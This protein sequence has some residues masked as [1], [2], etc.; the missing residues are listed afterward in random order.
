MEELIEKKSRSDK[1]VYG[2]AEYLLG[3]LLLI[4]ARIYLGD[5]KAPLIFTPVFLLAGTLYL[6]MKGMKMSRESKWLILC[7]TAIWGW[8]LLEYLPNSGY[9]NY[10]L[11]SYM[12]LFLHGAG[13]YWVL[14]L[15]ESRAEKEIG[16]KSAM[17][18]LRGIIILPC[19]NFFRLFGLAGSL[20]SRFRVKGE[21]ISKEEQEKRTYISI[22]ILASIPV[23]I[24]ILPLLQN[25]DESFA[26][27]TRAVLSNFVDL[28]RSFFRVGIL[29]N[30][31]ALVI[32]CYL[33]GLF[34]GSFYTKPPKAVEKTI[35]P[36]AGVLTFS[37]IIC[38]V[39]LLFFAVKIGDT[40]S[41]LFNSS[42]N[43]VYSTYAREGFFEL[44]LI[45][46]FNFALFYGTKIF[47]DWD[48]KNVK[49][50][51][52][53]LAVETLGFIV[54]AFSKMSLYISVYGFT[55]KRVL[56]SWFMCVLFLEFSFL[57][58]NVWKKKNPIK[59]A[60]IFAAITFLM[61]A[62]SN[63]EL[64]MSLFNQRMGV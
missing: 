2:K 29:L 25:A 38:G 48:R 53:L 51:L 43:I 32:G 8:I 3:V 52:T 23:L 16:E 41:V 61:L 1:T 64:W 63:M 47:S 30:M 58:R 31:I 19:V 4:A 14:S 60:V 42:R 26:L 13:V 39:Y 46:M 21:D 45:A 50:M 20:I 36:P 55:C 40:V 17:D 34:Y 37:G 59:P 62:Y 33:F 24:V 54:L 22:G 49:R 10:E 44:C 56:T 35:L 9:C 11:M 15:G 12:Y 18:M 57:I 7:I 27:F 6:T 28:I 5:E